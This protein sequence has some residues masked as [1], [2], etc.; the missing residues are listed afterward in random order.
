MRSESWHK[1]EKSVQQFHEETYGLSI[2][3]IKLRGKSRTNYGLMGDPPDG[4]ALEF[5][6]G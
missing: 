4:A 5:D 2:H 6:I 1:K 3:Y